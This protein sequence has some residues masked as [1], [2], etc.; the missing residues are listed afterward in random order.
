MTDQQAKR[1]FELK[2][3][4][5][6]D[7]SFESPLAP[8]FFDSSKASTAL[9]VDVN[10]SSRSLTDDKTDFECVLAIRVTAKSENEVVFLVEIEQAGVVEIQGFSDAD[11]AMLLNI[12]APNSLL[13]YARE[14]ISSLV[15]K[16]GFPQLLLK[17]LNFERI[18]QQKLKADAE[19]AEGI[20]TEH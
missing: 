20:Q 16:G 7:V 6:K 1:V 10:L 12:A 4:Y 18:F 8:A 15:S 11:I 17:P 3:I 14:A 19:K 2:H 13:P 9:D 5:L